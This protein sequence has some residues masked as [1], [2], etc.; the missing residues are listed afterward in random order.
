[1]EKIG[2][3]ARRLSPA[4]KDISHIRNMNIELSIIQ[5]TRTF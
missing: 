2:E 5:H 4:T 1:M 3:D